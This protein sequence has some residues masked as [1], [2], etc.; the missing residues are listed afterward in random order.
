MNSQ[1]P[2]FKKI[3]TSPIRFAFFKLVKLP[4]AFIAG[5]KVGYIDEEKTVILVKHG[6]LNQNPFKS[7]YFAVQAMAAEMSTGLFPVGQTYKRS[8]A[9]SMLVVGLDAKFVKKATGLIAFT[10]TDGL[11]VAETIEDT[12]QS[13]EGK[14][15]VCKSIGTNTN[16]EVVAEFNITWS[17]KS[18]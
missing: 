4:A 5:L 7:M 2:A 12:I 16:G 11:M 18:K 14:T 13:K 9:V 1:F 10:C 3:I 8:P 17:F 6:W 15:I